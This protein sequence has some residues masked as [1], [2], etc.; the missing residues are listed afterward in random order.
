MPLITINRYYGPAKTPIKRPMSSTSIFTNIFAI[1]ILV[2][3]SS[4]LIILILMASRYINQ[5]KDD[6]SFMRI[7]EMFNIL[8]PV[9]GTWMG[10]L[11][12]FY[13][14]KDNFAAASQQAKELAES[15]NPTDQILEVQK[16]T[17]VMIKPNDAMLLLLDDLADF[18][19]QYLND[20]IGKMA[21]TQSER[22]PILQKD[23]L[24]FIFLIYRTTIERFKLGYLDGSI[25]VPGKTPL[26]HS[27]KTL[28]VNDMYES[29]YALFKLIQGLKYSFLPLTAT[30]D[31]VKAAMQDNSICQDVFITQ[32]GIRDEKV[33]GWITNNLVIE[34]A[35]LFKKAGTKG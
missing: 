6:Q 12:A 26:T 33:E 5:G 4:I 2:L 31:K 21:E 19:K 34:K 11:L 9:I 30:L 25:V 15:M 17:D 23:T 20:L 10:T 16:V 14:S 29:D 22:M 13:F 35:E 1:I 32:N 27:E 18:K 3:S 28:T 24:K 8:L 7:K